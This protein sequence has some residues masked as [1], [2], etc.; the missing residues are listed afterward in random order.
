MP[1]PISGGLYLLRKESAE[2]LLPSVL[3][4]VLQR[5]PEAAS[6]ILALDPR[7]LSDFGLRLSLGESISTPNTLFT[8]PAAYACLAMGFPQLQFSANEILAW[9]RPPE[10]AATAAA[11]TR[12]PPQPDVRRASDSV[13]QVGE[14]CSVEGLT[15]TIGVVKGTET[16]RVITQSFNA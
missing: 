3:T 12:R 5:P 9:R 10:A 8:S 11:A 2:D 16:Y 7:G 6:T 1:E 13:R 15:Q 14:E 4:P